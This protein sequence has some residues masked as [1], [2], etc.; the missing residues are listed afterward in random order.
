[1]NHYKTLQLDPS[2]DPEIIDAAYRRLARRYHPDVNRAS[3]AAEQMRALNEAYET[4]R[5]PKLRAAYDAQHFRGRSEDSPETKRS[6]R[7][8]APSATG[9]TAEDT[10]GNKAKRESPSTASPPDARGPSLEYLWLPVVLIV[11]P[12]LLAWG[13]ALLSAFPPARTTD[14]VPSEQRRAVLSLKASSVGVAIANTSEST[15]VYNCL[16][17][18]WDSGRSADRPL[19][20]TAI[21]QLRERVNW[22]PP[23][24]WVFLRWGAFERGNSVLL[25]ADQLL[26]TVCQDDNSDIVRRRQLLTTEHQQGP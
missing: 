19:E 17:T 13:A 24:G 14:L 10:K 12:I 7:S 8:T 5:D 9:S 11:I 22:I 16:V 20:S 15:P 2:A 21:A 26:E 25:G 6:A 23:G 3:N 18:I 1:M 4:L